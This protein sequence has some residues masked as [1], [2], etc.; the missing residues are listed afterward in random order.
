MHWVADGHATDDHATANSAV[1]TGAAV[2]L[3]SNVIALPFVSA[4]T[5]RLV[6]AHA[7]AKIAGPCWSTE[8]GAGDS[9]S[10]GD[11]AFGA[12]GSNVYA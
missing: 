10:S 1:T 9:S 7:S 3:G 8:V 12:A 11:D 6:D 5:H 2:E 4:A